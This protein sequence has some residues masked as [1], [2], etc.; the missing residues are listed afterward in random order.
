MH[1]L[2]EKIPCGVVPQQNK[3]CKDIPDY[4]RP[5]L[6]QIISK[7]IYFYSIFVE[8]RGFSIKITKKI[9]IVAKAL[10]RIA[11]SPEQKTKT[12]FSFAV[13]VLHVR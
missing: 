12:F 9:K 1:F 11:A 2:A 6:D 10:L 4:S 7:N 5:N 13:T 3:G 8:N